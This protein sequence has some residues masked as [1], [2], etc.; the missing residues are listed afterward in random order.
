MKLTKNSLLVC[1][2]F[3]GSSFRLIKV[4]MSA[5]YDYLGIV[6]SRSVIMHL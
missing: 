4:Q 1:F 6:F 5:E 2:I 3:Y